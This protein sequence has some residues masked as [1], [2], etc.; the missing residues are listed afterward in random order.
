MKR[1]EKSKHS[2]P[3]LQPDPPQNSKEAQLQIILTYFTCSNLLT[4]CPEGSRDNPNTIHKVLTK[5][6]SEILQPMSMKD[7][8]ILGE[9]VSISF[10]RPH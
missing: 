5:E 4:L 6:T 10:L 9:I 1:L 7:Q 8:H 2:S 3:R